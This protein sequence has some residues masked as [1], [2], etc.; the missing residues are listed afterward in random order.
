MSFGF[1]HFAQMQ[2]AGMTWL[3]LQVRW[4]GM[5]PAS[6]VQAQ[7][8]SARGGGFKV[9]LSVVGTVPNLAADRA[10]YIQKYSAYVAGLAQLNPDAMEVWNE[11]NIDR[12]WPKGRSAAG[13]M[14][15]C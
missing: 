12:E 5:S 4:D 3:K 8:N 11:P 2:Q 1:G 6:A 7:I 10:A 9:L 13:T 15:R 14:R